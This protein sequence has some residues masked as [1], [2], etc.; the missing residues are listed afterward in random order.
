MQH[1]S[2]GHELSAI[3]VHGRVALKCFTQKSRTCASQTLKRGSD[4]EK[5]KIH[6]RNFSAKMSIISNNW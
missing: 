1:A 5:H 4:T 3:F 6:E 2:F